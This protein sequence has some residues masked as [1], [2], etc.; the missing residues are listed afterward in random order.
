MNYK[1]NRNTLWTETF[2][3]ELVSAGV[4]YACISPGSRNTPLTLAFANNKSIK[5]YVLIDERSA[6]FFALGLAKS[7]N[8]SVALVCTSGTA[9]AE[10]Y[11]AIIEAY[12]QRVPLIVCT[13]DRPPELLDVGANQTINQNNLYKNHIR[14]FVDLGLPEP[15]TR[16]FK[17]IK[18][19]ARRAVYESFVRSRGQK[20]IRA[21]ISYGRN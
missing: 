6:A 19:T 2:V 14:W 18:S 11:P 12:Q 9:T 16:R 8:S 5:S 15:T 3:H 1:I 10:F 4:K 17:H 20:T 13:A 7:S 21:G